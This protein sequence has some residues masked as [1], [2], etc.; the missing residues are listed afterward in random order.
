VRLTDSVHQLTFPFTVV[1]PAGPAPRFVNA[2][3]VEGAAGLTLIDAGVRDSCPAILDTVRKLGRRPED[4]KTLLLTHAHPDHLGGAQAL[5][6]A[7]RCQVHLAAAERAWAEDTARQKR[8]RPVPGFDE[9]VEGPVRVDGELHDRQRLAVGAGELEVLAAPGHSPGSCAFF[10]AG[11]GVLVTGDALP[12]PGDMPIYDDYPQAVASLQ[13]LQRL[14]GVALLLESWRAP[15]RSPPRRFAEAQAWFDELD[16]A[17][18]A[19]RR[20]R[21]PV[22]SMELTREVVA[23]L[24]LPAFAANPLVARSLASHPPA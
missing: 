13:R 3:L 1:T 10:L 23:R 9:L 11:E 20:Q 5:C 24:E 12:V 6:A 21:G 22:E 15:E 2:F 18:R 8:E 17:V 16:E 19:V 7:C 4:L 14:E